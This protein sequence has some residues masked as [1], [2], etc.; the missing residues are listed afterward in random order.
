MRLPWGHVALEPRFNP[1]IIPTVFSPL[2]PPLLNSAR[3]ILDVR[4]ESVAQF[5]EQQ[6][7][8]FSFFPRNA[9]HDSE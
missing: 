9:L 2:F 1:F 4:K 7:E 6:L 8:F 3:L 5:C